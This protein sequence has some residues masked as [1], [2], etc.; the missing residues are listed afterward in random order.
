MDYMIGVDIGTTSVKTVLYDTAGKMQGYSNNLYPL[1]QDVPDMAEEDPELEKIAGRM[2]ASG[3][4]QWT[5]QEGL[6]SHVPT[7][8]IA[9]SLMM[10]Y[11]SMQDDTFTGKV[12]S[13]LRNGFGGHAMDKA[14]K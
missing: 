8:V 9:L 11:R 7:P 14:G 2:H 10:R 1:Y 4:G 3:E 6:D 13:A 12:V 5:V